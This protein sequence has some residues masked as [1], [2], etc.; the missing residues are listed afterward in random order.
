MS[1]EE[2]LQALIMEVKLLESHI[3]EISE[4]EALVTRI[5]LESR[6]AL[7]VINNL[8]EKEVEALV[9]IGAGAF[10]Y[11]NLSKVEKVVIGVG[12]DVIIEKS[13]ED[14]IAY[15]EKRL[16][17]LEENF[18]KLN[19]TKAEFVN[20]LNLKKAMVNNLVAELSQAQEPRGAE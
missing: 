6:A 7:E 2:Q 1:K 14:A 18:V 10:I 12:A 4:R 13:K 8:G 9:P 19:S 20:R 3:N 15:L 11:T 16:K 17:E 5:L